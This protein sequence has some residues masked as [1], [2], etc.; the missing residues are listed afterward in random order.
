MNALASALRSRY[1][2]CWKTNGLTPLDLGL[3]V[4]CHRRRT[5]GQPFA[6]LPDAP[7]LLR[8]PVQQAAAQQARPRVVD[9]SQIDWAQHERLVDPGFGHLLERPDAGQ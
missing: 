1:C 3:A 2:F 9:V 7:A 4:L 6:D 5:A 8:V